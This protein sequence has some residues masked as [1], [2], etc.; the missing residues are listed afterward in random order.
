MKKMRAALLLSI[1]AMATGCL[2][3]M[4]GKSTFTVQCNSVLGMG[5]ALADAEAAVPTGGKVTN[6]NHSESVFGL[7]KSSTIGG[8]K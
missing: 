7:M 2:S 3:V 4:Q 1:F 8:T 5:C 6:V